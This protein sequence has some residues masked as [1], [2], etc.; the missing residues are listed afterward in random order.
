MMIRSTR[1][2]FCFL[3]HRQ[4]IC[5]TLSDVQTLSINTTAVLVKRRLDPNK[6]AIIH[7]LLCAFDSFCMEVPLEMV[8]GE[9]TPNYYKNKNIIYSL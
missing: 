1:I 9:N 2:V 5:I 4:Q 6:I 3:G 7:G 8:W